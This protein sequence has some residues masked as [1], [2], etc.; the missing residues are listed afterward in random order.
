MLLLTF[1]ATNLLD[2]LWVI[3]ALFDFTI[4]DSTRNRAGV[5]RNILREKF[6]G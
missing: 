5:H 6:S 1:N 4:E 3:V 2:I